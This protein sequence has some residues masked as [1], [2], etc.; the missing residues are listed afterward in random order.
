MSRASSTGGLFHAGGG[1]DD[2]S[3][4]FFMD[5][6]VVMYRSNGNEEDPSASRP[7]SPSLQRSGS[8]DP[9]LRSNAMRDPTNSSGNNRFAVDDLGT[10][11]AS[12][13]GTTN[14]YDGDETSALQAILNASGE[15]YSSSSSNSPREA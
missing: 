11:L 1:D 9:Q 14:E 4:M 7:S 6:E 3:V 5:G 10:L 12:G 15:E 2:D 13:V 8:T